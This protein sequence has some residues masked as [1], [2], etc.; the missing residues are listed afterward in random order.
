ML[1]CPRKRFVGAA[2]N[3]CHKHL[4]D[5]CSMVT[6]LPHPNAHTLQGPDFWRHRGSQPTWRHAHC[7]HMPRLGTQAPQR[8]RR[9]RE[10][11]AC[12][13]VRRP[14]AV[15]VGVIGSL[16]N[17]GRNTVDLHKTW[18]LPHSAAGSQPL[19]MSVTQINSGTRPFT[20]K[21]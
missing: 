9:H 10:P 3:S 20:H 8:S 4:L 21:T 6:R 1:L 13:R 7:S 16:A 18:S 11:Q 5:P 12:R 2:P 19:M 15:A 17:Q 14:G